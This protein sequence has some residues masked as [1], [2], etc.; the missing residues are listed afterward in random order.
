MT[1]RDSLQDGYLIPDLVFVSLIVLQLLESELTMC[2][3]PAMSRL[4]M[5]LAA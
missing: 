1:H 5:T 2:S 4:L 3:R